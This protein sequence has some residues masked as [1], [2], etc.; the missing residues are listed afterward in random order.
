[1]GSLGKREAEVTLVR[2][3]RSYIGSRTPA[4]LV[5]QISEELTEF[6]D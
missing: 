3:S 1:M 5:M 2:K 6:L 4:V